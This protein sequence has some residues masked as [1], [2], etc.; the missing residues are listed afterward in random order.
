MNDVRLTGTRAKCALSVSLQK[1]SDKQASNDVKYVYGIPTRIVELEHPTIEYNEVTKTTVLKVPD[2]FPQGSIAVVETWIVDVDRDLDSYINSGAE[3]AVKALDL[4]DLNVLLY[5]C[6]SEEREYSTG[7]DGVYNIPEFGSLS[8]AGLQGWISPLEQIVLTNDVGHPICNNLRQ[9]HWAL[10]YTVDRLEKYLKDFPNLKEVFEWLKS[11]FTRIKRVPSFVLPR[12]FAIVIYNLYSASRARSLSLMSKCIGNG[13]FFL[14]NLALTSIQMLGK[15]PSTSIFPFD[16][17]GSMAAGLPHFSHDY[18]RC[19]GRDVFISL[20]GLLLVTGRFEEAK[21]HILAFAA[22]LKHGLIPN[23]LDAGRDPRYNARDATWFFLQVIQDYCQTVPD[24]VKLLDV[25]VKRRFPLDDT[26][27]TIDDKR[28]FSES[29][30]IRE[31]IY[32][33]L[34]RH[35]K[36][37]HFRE[38]NAGSNLDSQMRDEGFNQKIIVDWSNGMIFGGNEWNCGTWMDKMGESAKAGNQGIP[39]TPRDGAAIEITGL[40]K[41]TLRWINQLRE[42]NL[43]D[44][45]YVINQY[46]EKVALEEWD[47]ILQSKFEYCY[48]VPEDSEMDN[49]FDVNCLV[50][51]RR[52]IYKDLYRS[53]KEYEDY[54]LRPNFA[55]AMTVA[56]ELFNV[57]HA[58]GAIAMADSIIRGPVGM[59]TLDP[60][61]LNYR[62]YYRNSVDNNDFATAKGRNY[63]QGPEWIWCSGYF[64]RAFMLFDLTRKKEAGDM[65]Y[66]STFQQLAIR[67]QGA[68][69]WI[70]TSPWAGLTELTNKDGEVCDD[71]SP[72]Q[73]WSS[74]TLIEVFEDARL[75]LEYHKREELN[76][77]FKLLTF[78]NK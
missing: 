27:V 42:N 38:A 41:S 30:T 68:R 70:R 31:I 40:L 2:Y 64:L 62:P 75:F 32:E 26:Y 22:T 76:G 55:L 52:G 19:W 44:W 69:N 10:D 12:Y 47:R 50:I 28:A 74:A 34:S 71:S 46:G 29:T 8:Y 61:D 49:Q 73:A 35:A 1:D 58:L 3:N 16:N 48:Y 37:I 45:D 4:L 43:F 78:K 65:D 67:L 23:L 57:D 9:G 33:I 53:S 36:G 54:Q 25:P 7:Q 13:T 24:G 59:K 77:G 51:H 15:V 56:P 11:R 21:Q 66:E 17:V 5:K 63:H 18:M 60:E 6:D 14:Q 39:G 72:T 20:R